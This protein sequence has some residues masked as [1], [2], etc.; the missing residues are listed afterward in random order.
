MS[1]LIDKNT[2]VICQGMTG[3][4]GTFQS[5]RTLA[6]GTQ[7]L[8]GVTPGK[9]GQMHLDLPVFDTVHEAVAATGAT[10]SILY[11]PPAMTQNAIIEAVSANIKLIVC[12]TE[13][14]PIL[15]ILSL[16]PLL[17]REG[18][19]LIG[20]NTPGIITPEECMLGIM[21]H[22]IF[23]RGKVGIITRSGTLTYEVVKQTT[24]M[25]F[26]QSTCVGIGGDVIRGTSIS[27]LLDMFE[28][29]AATEVI[30][31]A[32]EIGGN[33]EEEAAMYIR[34]HITKPV[35]A[36]I[37]GRY[38]PQGRRMGHAGAIV[39]RSTG[40]ALEK[41]KALKKA[42]VLVADSI[43]EVGHSVKKVL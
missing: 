9:G 24:E 19:Y 25:G 1:I 41:S 5:Q 39:T 15:D 8:A 27:T 32:G 2:R 33:A 13:G 28:K 31:I 12:I 29:D 34:H 23:K 38:A 17:Q 3:R 22:N 43:T 36:Y 10:A 11:V 20:P 6:Y 4:V 30:V 37:A 14:I 21:P 7:L 35:V 42:G 40:S 18:V 16:K 26:G